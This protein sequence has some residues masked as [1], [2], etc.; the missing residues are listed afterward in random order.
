VPFPEACESWYSGAYLL[1]TVPCVL[2]IL[3]CHGADDEG[4]I[5]QLIE[6]ARMRWWLPPS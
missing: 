6:E 3:M 1:E 5:P 4:R 2:Y